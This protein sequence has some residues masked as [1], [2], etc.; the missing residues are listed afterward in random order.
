MSATAIRT[1]AKKNADR[2]PL[3][4]DAVRIDLPPMT[5]PQMAI[6]AIDTYPERCIDV[7]GSPRSAKSWGIGFLIWKLV[8]T[9]PGIQVFYTRYKDEGLIQLR[10]VWSKVSVYF[11]DYLRPR[12]N[13]E[14]QSWDFPNGEW[15]GGTSE[16]DGGV[17]T[18]S[19]VYLS[20]L[21][22]AEAMTADAVHGKYKGK[23]LAVVI[24]EEAQEIPR[25]N[26]RGLKERLSQSRTPLGEPYRYP[27]KI[28]L[29]HNSVDEDH[30][31][32]QEFPLGPDGDTC[33]R[34]GHRHIRADLYSNA[35][36]LGPDV[37]AGYEQ[38]YP[39]G[40]TLRR[41]VMEGKRGVT[42]LGEPVYGGLYKR[43]AH[44]SDL[45][46]FD[47]NYPL[48]EGWDFGEEK[49]AVVWLQYLRHL[50]AIR[51]LG[52][53]KGSHL[54]LELFAPK[55]LEIRRRLFP[56]A[57]QIR[58]WCDP[59]GVTGNGGLQWTPIK[60]LHE[61]GIPAKPAKEPD[62]SRDGNDAEVRSKAIQI[63]GGYMTKVGLDGLPAFLMAPTCIELEWQGD[64]IAEKESRILVTAFEAGYIW[65]TRA[66][67]DAH[68]NIRKPKKGTRY[69]DLMNALEYPVIGEAIPLAPS[70]SMLASAQAHYQSAE[71][72][73]EVM[74]QIQ[75]RLAL[76]KEQM[77]T[78][79]E[80]TRRTPGGQRV[81]VMGRR[82]GGRAGY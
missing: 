15:V 73:A 33:T 17:Y 21:R 7:E 44:V 82:V 58:S 31:I 14:D 56:H 38:D 50:A 6:L 25:I 39:P 22:V 61:H 45:A 27:L 34:E 67:S 60:L 70:V 20:S 11:P 30:W 77:D 8:Y 57:T 80:D 10:D 29:V 47:R 76:R 49:P 13:T 12:W 69:D 55:V 52:A 41:T 71:G 75:S 74:R 46:R 9:Y 43:A 2:P 48:L 18:G 37:M 3:G 51:I 78:H 81:P 40:A 4:T 53:V 1:N 16:R 79:R 63:V 59:T 66:P 72:R 5:G 23:T 19:R 42:L 64:V 36:N 28:V 54:F 35:Q 62:T 26:Y 32:A 68:P 65:D 24:C